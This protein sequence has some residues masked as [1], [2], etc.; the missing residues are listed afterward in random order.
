MPSCAPEAA[1]S[2]AIIDGPPRQEKIHACTE[3]AAAFGVHPGQRLSAALALDGSLRL[4]ARKPEA[5]QAALQRLAGWA[6]Q[7]TPVVIVQAPDGL[8]LDIGS[9]LAYFRGLPRLLQLVQQGLAELGYSVRTACAPSCH[10]AVWLARMGVQEPV[11]NEAGLPLALSPLPVSLLPLPVT[12]QEKLQLM[13]IDTLGQLLQL[14]RGG[15]ARRFGNALPLLLDQALALAPDPRPA[16][17]APAQFH[18]RLEL[19]WAADSCA[20]LLFVAR[21]ML[22]ELCGYL[23][24]RSLG[25][26]SITLLLEH[27]N[28]STTRLPIGFGKPG[29]NADA[30]F[31]ILR[32]RL[33]RFELSASVAAVAL[34]ADSLHELQGRM[35]DL[36][37]DGGH[38]EDMDLLHNRLR[39]RLGDAAVCSVALEADHRPE[40]AWRRVEVGTAPSRKPVSPLPRV[41][42]PAWLLPAPERLPVLRDR[43]WYGEALR[44]VGRPERIESGW[45]DGDAVVRDYFMARGLSSGRLFWV[46]QECKSQQWFMHGLFD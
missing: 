18:S 5:E 33:E 40:R 31:A 38:D 20:D 43:P 24:G 25:V 36:F 6:Q 17:Q 46:F 42:R 22:V 10:A 3:A 11:H 23:A 29:R 35:Q 15:L 13:G 1:A 32:E 16:F 8:L 30:L 2:W 12:Q 28:R 44:C 37:G 26:Q 14:P 7:F 9:C 39:A 19:T 34:Q 21:R 27:E 4:C 45:W 41:R